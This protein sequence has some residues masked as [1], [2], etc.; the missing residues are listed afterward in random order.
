MLH[1]GTILSELRM[2]SSP[3]VAMITGATSGI[4]LATARA[5]A[6]SGARLHLVARNADKA[7]AMRLQLQAETGNADLHVWTGDLARQADIHR[8]ADAFLASGSPLHLLVN[9]A[10][11]V[12]AR[13]RESP[14]G[15]EETFAVNHLAYFLLTE[16]LRPR[17][18]DSA[19]ARIVSTASAAHS[20]V[21]GMD[22]EDP[23]WR[24]RRY[25]VLP[26]YGQS[27][28]CNILWTRELSRQL[29]GSGVT[30]NCLHPGAVG[31][32]LAAQNGALARVV[33]GLLKPF[34]RSPERGAVGAIHLA[35][36][37]EVEQVS[38][39]YFIDRRIGRPR[40]WAQDDAAARRLWDL[41]LAYTAV[42]RA[43]TDA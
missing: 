13:W 3:R 40:P 14:D 39:E 7:E 15:I 33:M 19:P 28:L 5:L 38:G 12:N 24:R 1:S 36:A 30:A 10:G 26:I 37:P 8:I 16:R 18:V 29:R 4:G 25:Q 41:S 42:P 2:S 31:T 21:R 34:F 9:N 27:K 23:E 22:F 11:I 35:L 17:L 20:F 32:G 43:T 6:R